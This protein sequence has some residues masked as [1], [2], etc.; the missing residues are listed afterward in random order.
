MAAGPRMVR[1]MGAIVDEAERAGTDEARLAAY[2]QLA[3]I[4]RWLQVPLDDGPAPSG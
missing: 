3:H 4:V 1:R 2:D